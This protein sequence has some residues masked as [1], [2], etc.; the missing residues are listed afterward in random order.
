MVRIHS[1]WRLHPVGSP[2]S[3]QPHVAYLET[4]LATV[5]NQYSCSPKLSANLLFWHEDYGEWEMFLA[6]NNHST[7]RSLANFMVWVFCF[8][9]CPKN[10]WCTTK[11]PQDWLDSLMY[12][13]SSDGQWGQVITNRHKLI[14]CLFAFNSPCI[15][16]SNHDQTT[17]SSE[18]REILSC[19]VFGTGHHTF[20][21]PPAKS[22]SRI[23]E[24]LVASYGS[25]IWLPNGLV[26]TT[27]PFTTIHHSWERKFE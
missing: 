21:D 14:F 5:I 12:S 27:M 4:P 6:V 2:A 9:R 19:A 3:I 26:Q 7:Y 8:N 18:H 20:V 1:G 11:C 16:L 15:M 24:I 17:S 10:L 23:L 13:F 25:K 22:E